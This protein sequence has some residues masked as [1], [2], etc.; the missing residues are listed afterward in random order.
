[1]IYKSYFIEKQINNMNEKLFLFFGENLGLQNDFK[2][3]IKK[4]NKDS[5]IINIYQDE[6][7]QNKNLLLNEISNI[8]LFSLI[9]LM[10]KFVS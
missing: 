3:M 8:S 7:L 10:I 9:N 5:E 1:M 6:I 4:C 2:K